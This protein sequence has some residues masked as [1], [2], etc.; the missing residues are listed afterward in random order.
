MNASTGSSLRDICAFL[1]VHIC[2]TTDDSRTPDANERI[3]ILCGHE[4]CGLYYNT[5]SISDYIE[6]IV[7]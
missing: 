1:Y 2:V 4:L 3:Y 7:G 6:S 5:N